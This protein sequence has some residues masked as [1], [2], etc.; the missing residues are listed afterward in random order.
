MQYLRREWVAELNKIY[1]HFPKGGETDPDGIAE[2]LKK[3]DGQLLFGLLMT[4]N[5]LETE[6]V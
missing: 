6:A 5:H 2:Y 4:V 3:T 1:E